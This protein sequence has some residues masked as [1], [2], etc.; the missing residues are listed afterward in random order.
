MKPLDENLACFAVMDFDR[1]R[2]NLCLPRYTPIGWWECDVFELTAKDFFREYEVKLSLADFRA[3]AK[4]NGHGKYNWQTKEYEGATN[5]HE[6]LAKGDPVGPCQ[7]SFVTPVDLVP[8]AELPSWA[9]LLELH[10]RGEGYRPTHRW[11]ISEKV[12]A[13]KLHG[14]KANPKIRQAMLGCCYYRFHDALRANVNRADVAMVW[15]DEP[16]PVLE[17]E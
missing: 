13:P 7:F 9:G 2:R 4:K 17:V 3:D 14:A 6:L 1:V 16:A 12:K 10:D 5:K 11:T 8:M 15:P